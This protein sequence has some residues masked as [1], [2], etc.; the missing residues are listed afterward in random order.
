MLEVSLLLS[1]GRNKRI[2]CRAKL[3]LVVAFKEPKD[4]I[5]EPI[6][7]GYGSLL[8]ESFYTWLS[9]QLPA[10]EEGANKM[11]QWVKNVIIKP[12]DLGSTP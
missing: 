11:A 5:S 2:L 4:S 12:D 7:A 6:S 1:V 10:P 8:G 3:C 9:T